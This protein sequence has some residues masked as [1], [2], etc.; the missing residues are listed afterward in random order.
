MSSDIS[1]LSARYACLT[2]LLMNTTVFYDITLGET[3]FRNTSL[4][5]P[6]KRSKL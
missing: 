5:G 2:A 1:V 3:I 4:N 6:Q